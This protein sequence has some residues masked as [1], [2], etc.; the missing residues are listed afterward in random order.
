MHFRLKRD[1]EE[2]GILG[3]VNPSPEILHQLFDRMSRAFTELE[4]ERAGLEQALAR[5]FHDARALHE[6][7]REGSDSTLQDEQERIRLIIE[8]ALDA[9]VG[10]DEWGIIVD[11]NPSAESLFGWTKEEILGCSLA[12]TLIPPQFRQAHEDD[13]KKFFD[14]GQSTIVNQRIEVTA[15]RRDGIEFPI[16]LAIIPIKIGKRQ[17]FS[18]F[19]RDISERQQQE[20]AIKNSEERF[21]KF[22]NHSIDAI[23]VL[24]PKEDRIVEANQRAADM[25]EYSL[26]ELL[27]V[28]VSHI[29]SQE[30]PKLESFFQTVKTNGSGWT[31]VLTC[32][33]KFGRRLS[34]EIAASWVEMDGEG[35]LIAMVRD[36]TD[37]HHSIDLMAQAAELLEQ[38]NAELIEARDKALEGARLKSEFLATMSHEIR[39]PMNGVIG[40]TGLLLETPLAPDQR[41]LAETVRSSGEALLTIINDILDFSKIESGKLD[42]EFVDFDLR[43]AVEEC[44]DL[45]SER[46]TN[47]GLEL[48]GL[49][50]S[51]VP[52]G[53]QGDPGRLRQILLNLVS[54]AI[55]FTA[56]GDVT[57]RVDR[58]EESSQDVVLKFHV[59]DTGIGIPAAS[60]S[61]LFQ[62]FSQADGSTTRRYEGT[63]LGL[64]I[65]KQL[66]EQMGGEIGF[67]SFLNQGSRFWFTVCLGKPASYSV[68]L[69]PNPEGLKGFRICCVDDN[70]TNCELLKQYGEEW[71]MFVTTVPTSGEGLVVL[72][73]ASQDGNPYDLALLDMHMPGMDGL[74]LG[75]LIKATPGISE[76]K[77]VLLTSLGQRGDGKI[78][79]EAGFSGYLTKP[80]R[81][82]SLKNCLERIMGQKFEDERGQ[83]SLVTV[84]SV[85]EAAM[86]TGGYILIADDHVVNQQLTVMMLERLGCKADVVGN[87][88]EALE[89][90]LRRPYDLVLMD[91][92]M[93]EMDGYEATKRIRRMEFLRKIERASGGE[94]EP[95]PPSHDREIPIIAMTANAMQGDREKCLAVGMNDYLAKPLKAGKLVEILARWMPKEEAGE[96]NQDE[97][98][99]QDSGK[100][101][102]PIMMIAPR[103]A[104]IESARE[105]SCDTLSIGTQKVSP[106][107]REVLEEIQSLVGPD[108]P[109]FLSKVLGQFI[110]E[111]THCVEAIQ[112]AV[113]KGDREALAEAA[114]GLKGISGNIGAY[115]LAERAL[116]LEQL[117]KEGRGDDAIS[118]EDLEREFHE[119]KCIIEQDYL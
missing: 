9:I 85:N 119:A 41:N 109:D 45:L 114:H 35:L 36:T 80:V 43:I 118:L 25:L 8:H 17:S 104:S 93:P 115:G 69:I 108:N 31:D 48:V 74:T 63:G 110:Q 107:D 37:K 15:L 98:R 28:P 44:L 5:S 32:Q 81:Q 116:R 77:L 89:A 117:A 64:A 100:D 95:C 96:E 26:D 53:L 82:A 113:E 68:S 83:E 72:Q 86:K 11:W 84:H 7:L 22:F 71:G 61:K 70:A 2:L 21:R 90:V 79:K 24:D 88:Q 40:M 111:A 39:T 103:D 47:K 92:Q 76:V 38:K 34:A 46:A 73:E 54:N 101:E 6:R 30:F 10:M 62:P 14:E 112:R 60:Q 23:F 20:S 13:L 51:D 3:E 16:E 97:F 91:C 102:A 12:S 94:D 106:L 33:T 29:H 67:E 57:V 75:Q 105:L 50:S 42:F 56:Q 55:K 66:A 19:I 87:G 59:T 4:Q 58:V 27:T 99:S 52:T 1:L 78:A 18:V 49:V 65:C